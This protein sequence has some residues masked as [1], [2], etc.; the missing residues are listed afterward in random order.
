M[1]KRKGLSDVEWKWAVKCS[2]RP[3]SH[4][5]DS[6]PD[7]AQACYRLR[8]LAADMWPCLPGSNKDYIANPKELGYQ[9]LHLTVALEPPA[10]PGGALNQRTEPPTLG[11]S[12]A[13][14]TV[15]LQ[16]RTQRTGLVLNASLVSTKLLHHS[17][18][19]ASIFFETPWSRSLFTT[20]R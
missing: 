15:E 3:G 13:G 20:L 2:S 16:F 6:N 9:S 7:G 14:P 18:F 17:N 5:R 8:D 1:W 4:G 11:P 10:V 19:S 12:S